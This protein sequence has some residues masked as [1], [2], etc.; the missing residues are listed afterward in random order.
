MFTKTVFP[1]FAGV[2][3]LV[4]LAFCS[5]LPAA[6]GGKELRVLCYNIHVGIGMDKE[7]DLPRVAEVIKAQKPDLVALQEVDYM[8]E[9]TKKVDQAKTLGQLTGMHH[10]FGR[11][12]D[13][14]GGHYG[15]A[16]LSKFP[17]QSHTI[18]QLPRLE[19][20][21]DRGALETILEVPEGGKMRFVC[22]HFCHINEERRTKQ[23]EKINE[24]FTKDELLTIV[25]GDFNAEPE[26]PTIKKMN[27]HWTDATDR[28]PTFSSTDPKIKIDYVFYR[29]KDKLKLKE[30]K[31]IEE[32]LASDHRPVLC[33][34]EF[35]E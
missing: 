24:L 11:T 23:A 34:L 9:R 32:K 26:S 7:L 18:T 16:I 5:P 4:A 21:E 27:E 13:L 6:E 14:T 10:A 22:T 30:T 15:I 12:I 20:Q 29:P 35:V 8:T 25:A 28:T 17:I 1:M 19:R 3:T 33:V 31:V 2:L